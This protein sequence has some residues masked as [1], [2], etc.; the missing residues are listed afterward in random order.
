M[1]QGLQFDKVASAS[2]EVVPADEFTI[3]A[4][5]A[6]DKSKE[7]LVQRDLVSKKAHF[8]HRTSQYRG[9]TR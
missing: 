8:G 4:A 3:H 7:Q 6:A 5:E 1:G 2:N 9:V